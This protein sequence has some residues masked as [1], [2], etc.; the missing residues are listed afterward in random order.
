MTTGNTAMKRSEYLDNCLEGPEGFSF[1][2]RYY[3][4]YV[5]P[6]IISLVLRCIGKA[7][8]QQSVAAGHHSFT[9][10]PLA[11]WDAMSNALHQVD[12]KLRANGDSPTPAVY[13]CILK[14]AARQIVEE[15]GSE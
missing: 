14:E 1:H 12:A 9:D 8:L 2:R 3:A 10:I 4:Q 6:G 15:E 11:K 5:T 7:D 13:V